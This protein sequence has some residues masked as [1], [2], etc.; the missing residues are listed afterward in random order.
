MCWRY[1]QICFFFFT[2]AGPNAEGIHVCVLCVRCQLVL[3]ITQKTHLSTLTSLTRIHQGFGF[4]HLPPSPAEWGLLTAYE[5]KSSKKLSSTNL[6]GFKSSCTDVSKPPGQSINFHYMYC[7]IFQPTLKVK[8]KNLALTGSENNLITHWWFPP[9][10]C[11]NTSYWQDKS[12]STILDRNARAPSI[13]KI[14]KLS[15]VHFPIS[16]LLL[17]TWLSLIDTATHR[18]LLIL[19]IFKELVGRLLETHFHWL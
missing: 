7:S 8:T 12:T 10:F 16:S 17:L 5:N 13:Q 3:Q 19:C 2:D 9:K 15:S 1:F 18:S 6:S 14:C 4:H 11:I